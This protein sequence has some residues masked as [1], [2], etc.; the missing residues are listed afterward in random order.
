AITRWLPILSIVVGLILSATWTLLGAEIP[1]AVNRF[2]YLGI[3]G[4]AA[5]LSAS[6]LWSTAKAVVSPKD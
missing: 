1:E 3:H 6:G 5:G 2:A 4:V